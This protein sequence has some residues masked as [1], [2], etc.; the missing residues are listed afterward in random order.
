MTKVKL[1]YLKQDKNQSTPLWYNLASSEK[2]ESPRSYDYQWNFPS[3]NQDA[4]PTLTPNQFSHYTTLSA[5]SRPNKLYTSVFSRD[6]WI[7][8]IINNSTNKAH[9]IDGKDINQQ[10]CLYF[11]EQAGSK[12]QW[13]LLLH[14][15]KS[16]NKDFIVNEK[17]KFDNNSTI[18]KFDEVSFKKDK[19]L[20][21]IEANDKDNES[22]IFLTNIKFSKEFE[23]ECTHGRYIMGLNYEEAILEEVIYFEEEEKE[24]VI[25]RPRIALNL[26]A[27]LVN[28]AENGVNEEVQEL[29]EEIQ[30]LAEEPD[31][32]SELRKQI[33]DFLAGSTLKWLNAN[34]EV[35]LSSAE[36]N[37]ALAITVEKIKENVEKENVK[38]DTITNEDFDRQDKQLDELDQLDQLDELFYNLYEVKYSDTDLLTFFADHSMPGPSQGVFTAV[39][40]QINSASA[41]ID[42]IANNKIITE[43]STS[44]TAGI[45]Q[46]N[47]E[48][49]GSAIKTGLNFREIYKAIKD[50]QNFVKNH[51]KEEYKKRFRSAYTKTLKICAVNTLESGTKTILSGLNF[52]AEIGKVINVSGFLNALGKFTGPIGAAANAIVAA[53]DVKTMLNVHK[54]LEKL[55]YHPDYKVLEEVYEGNIHLSLV[56]KYL[57]PKL[58][59]KHGRH[60]AQGVSG[61]LGVG[62]AIVGFVNIWNPIGWTLMAGT[63]G[64]GVGITVYNGYRRFRKKKNQEALS[65][66]CIPPS[67]DIFAHR[68]IAIAEN[69]IKELPDVTKV[70]QSM[71]D[72]SQIK[73]PL[74]QTKPTNS[75][76]VSEIKSYLGSK[77]ID[78][79]KRIIKEIFKVKIEYNW[80]NKESIEAV[81]KTII[82]QIR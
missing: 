72:N 29:N 23:R 73:W 30:E 56:L 57:I 20:A 74:N 52:A 32:E 75:T 3:S 50:K 46:L 65:S 6:Q 62:V 59:R 82:R 70:L 7:I 71:K 42:A 53:R 22:D 27:D 60:L 18:H 45:A 10:G 76:Q 41:L 39:P 14:N 47:I 44:S 8:E 67:A 16:I 79:A 19:A 64:V 35:N 25:I 2:I 34:G 69:Q 9:F 49:V 17:F 78:I 12:G 48:S 51:G 1:W 28:K 31:I 15:G 36:I 68:L 40:A 24:G 37:S 81:K 26:S 61:T 58:R 54:K 11:Y 63:V 5:I 77:E 33:T 13:K 38:K 21:K 4:L 43:G 66:E 80:G 55:V